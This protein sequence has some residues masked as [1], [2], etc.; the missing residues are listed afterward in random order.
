MVLFLSCVS[1]IKKLSP[2]EC[3]FFYINSEQGLRL[4]VIVVLSLSLPFY[5]PKKTRLKGVVSPASLGNIR[6]LLCDCSVIKFSS[7]KWFLLF[8]LESNCTSMWLLSL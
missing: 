5:H 4:Y 7:G 3:G 2:L 8:L 6:R 1:V